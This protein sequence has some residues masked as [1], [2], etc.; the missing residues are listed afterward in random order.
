MGLWESY[1]FLEGIYV[2]NAMLRV[3]NT[4]K[5]IFVLISQWKLTILFYWY[6]EKLNLCVKNLAILELTLVA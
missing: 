5:F 2:R 4:I 1:F 3:R 6:N